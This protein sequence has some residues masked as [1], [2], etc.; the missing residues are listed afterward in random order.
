M[1]Y[2][3]F[4]PIS[5]FGVIESL[6][7]ACCELGVTTHGCDSY[8]MTADFFIEIKLILCIFLFIALLELIPSFVEQSLMSRDLTAT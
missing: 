2:V 1:F 6:P 3:I 4:F 7:L 8:I 5:E